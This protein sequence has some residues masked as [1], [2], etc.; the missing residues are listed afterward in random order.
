MI[1]IFDR[2]F[3]QTLGQRFEV[4]RE[5]GRFKK[6]EGIAVADSE[7]EAALAELHAKWADEFAVDPAVVTAI[8]ELVFV[9]SRKSQI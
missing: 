2:D 5:I 7:R 3:I 1:E 9:E 8:F 4:C 6:Q